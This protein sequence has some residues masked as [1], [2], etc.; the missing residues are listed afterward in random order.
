MLKSKILFLIAILLWVST[1]E[2]FSYCRIIGRQPIFD[3]SW[4]PISYVSGCFEP[5]YRD[6]WGNW[7]WGHIPGYSGYPT[8]K[9]WMW[10]GSI[11]C[12]SPCYTWG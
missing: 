9:G 2:A 1:S 11:N 6:L 8:M 4:Q 10:V 5:H 7:W 3:R 12:R